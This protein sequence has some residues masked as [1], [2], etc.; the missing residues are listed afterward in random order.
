MLAPY[1]AHWEADVVLIDGGTAHLRPITPEDA[2]RLR[3]FHRR[4]S[5]QSIY[6]RFFAPYPELTERDVHRFTHVDHHDRVAIIATIGE[7][8]VGVVRYDRVSPDEAEVAFNIADAHQGRGLGSV[9][10]EHIATAAQEQG[11]RRFV[12]EVL[13]GNR[14]M[15]GVFTDAGYAVAS[16]VDEGVVR[17]VFDI[18]PTETSL[19]VRQAR[20]HRAESRSIQRL[21]NPGSVAVIGASRVYDSIGQTVLRNLLAGPFAGPIYAVNPGWPEV[22]GLP[23]YASVLDV[24]GSVDVAV[25]AVPADAGQQVIAE[26]ARK[27][28]R[29]V[30]VLSA[31]YAET[32]PEGR[33]RQHHLVAA[34][35]ANGMRVVG[36]NSFGL[37]NTDPAVRLNASLAP[38]MPPV[39]RA[40]FFSQSGALGIALL[41]TLTQRG[42]G[43]SSF[44]SAGNRADVSGNDLLQYWEEDV[45][46]DVV[47]L[48]LESIGN[49]RKFSRL[50]RR[51]AGRKPV[52]TVKSGRA[53]QGA[54]LGHAVEVSSVPTAAVDAMFAQ[55]GVIRVDT[56]HQLFDVGQL[57]VAQPLPSGNRVA[58][59][60]N[61]QALLLLASDACAQWDLCVVGEPIALGAEASAEDYEW[62]L[63]EV[64][65]DPTVDS[66]VAVFIPPVA[67]TGEEVAA[68][69]AATAARAT[70][71][72]VSTFL[73]LRG[74]PRQLRPAAGSDTD[75]D[76]GTAS[77]EDSVP[78][79]S[80]PSYPTPEEAVGALAL[81]SQYADWRRRPRGTVPALDRCD[82]AGARGF[83][84]DVLRR[85]PD[86]VQLGDSDAAALLDFYGVQ[87]EPEAA[88]RSADEAVQAADRLGYP[89]VLKSATEHLRPRLDLGEVE[90]NL[91]SPARVRSAYARMLARL[92]DVAGRGAIVQRMTDFGVACVVESVEDAL[93]GPIV[94][95]GVGGVATELLG[96]RAYRIPPLT[97]TDVSAMV[98]SIRAAP[99]LFGYKGDDPV[100]IGALEELLLR[101]SRLA[102]DLPEVA[103]LELNPVLAGGRGLAVL[104]ARVRLARPHA[105][106]DSGPRR[107]PV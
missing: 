15:L 99:L 101:V 56:I 103:E 32:G 89:V 17:L 16:D 44:V 47:M 105:R 79:G 93:F 41:E 26:C 107:L 33:E 40:G 50:A 31:G 60:G 55:A 78:R 3:D 52:V 29:G 61:S 92:G 54:P 48:Y 20:E 11:V 13:P 25:V 49:P 96:D 43:L 63:A 24:V 57:L 12:A 59:L 58:I 82:P 106:A 76:D 28:V 6:F 7:D 71:T 83:V 68:V 70:K 22:A 62:A 91:G 35:R 8:I 19:A 34:A 104:H 98:R 85:Q 84:D 94:S 21:L 67:S 9:L 100:D 38:M 65:A 4:Q 69:L 27:G 88:V 51:V 37:L 23:T 42:L 1:P 86:G 74:V 53:A 30:V 5:E 46:T 77:E 64:F 81:V 90:V 80:V 95:F 18:A 2:D 10:L 72:V 45:R 14:R 66:V 102:D 87:V 39:G 73:G 36:P 97:D 75:K